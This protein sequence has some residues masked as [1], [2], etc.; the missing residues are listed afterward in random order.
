MRYL[1]FC[2]AILLGLSGY[3][4]GGTIDPAVDDSQYIEYG[5]NTNAL[6]QYEAY[7]VNKVV[8]K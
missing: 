3:I 5:K 8:K 6:F 2:L 4:N 7:I 1:T